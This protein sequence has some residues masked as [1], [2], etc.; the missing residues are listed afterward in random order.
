M[1]NY[2]VWL[3]DLDDTVQ[4]GPLSWAA[5]NLFPEIAAQ[6]GRPLAPARFEE[7]Y[8]RAHEL[9]DTGADETTLVEA[10]FHALDWPLTLVPTVIERF[11]H[12]YRPAL[13]D[14]TLEFLDRLSSKGHILYVLS[15]SRR[16]RAVVNALGLR[17]YFT[18]VLTPHECAVAAKPTP[19][20]W[21]YLKDRIGISEAEA[22]VVGDNLWTDGLFAKNC[23]LD[24]IIVDRF[25]LYTSTGPHKLVHSLQE[26]TAAL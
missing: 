7:G 3:L 14:D 5:V 12:D 26:L 8:A 4:V 19:A 22:V 20:L 9:F 23:G 21:H 15:N 18:D 24:C 6:A 17:H 1:N 16:A 2:K 13:F 25:R 10:I 11:H